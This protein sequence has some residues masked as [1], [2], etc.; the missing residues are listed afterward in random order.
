MYV[1]G[2]KLKRVGNGLEFDSFTSSSCNGGL[3]LQNDIDGHPMI[4]TF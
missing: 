2:E 1:N 4:G 3:M